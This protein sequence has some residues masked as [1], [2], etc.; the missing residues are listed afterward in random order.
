MP[1]SRAQFV[2]VLGPPPSSPSLVLEE[3][4]TYL[5]L[6]GGGDGVGPDTTRGPICAADMNERTDGCAVN[7]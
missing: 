7:R 4:N 6:D 2:G 5:L 1:W 3:S